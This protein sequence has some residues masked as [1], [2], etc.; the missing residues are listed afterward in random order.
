MPK[1]SRSLSPLGVIVTVIF[2]LIAVQT[3]TAS[4]LTALE[5]EEEEEEV[6]RPA[7]SRFWETRAL[8]FDERRF[9]LHFRV[10]QVVFNMVLERI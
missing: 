3:Q 6:E 10:P 4:L 2:A 7:P 1:R 5:M 8:F 9:K